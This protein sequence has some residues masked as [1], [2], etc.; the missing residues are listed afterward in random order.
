MTSEVWRFSW[1]QTDSKLV[2]DPFDNLGSIFSMKLADTFFG[3][4]VIWLGYILV[5]LFGNPSLKKNE[6]RPPPEYR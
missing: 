4:T 2:K 3:N 5:A 6:M 1:L